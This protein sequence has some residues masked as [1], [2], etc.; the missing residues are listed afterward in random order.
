MTYERECPKCGDD[1]DQSTT[2]HLKGVLPGMAEC[3]VCY[4]VRYDKCAGCQGD[5]YVS[6]RDYHLIRK[7]L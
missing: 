5:G 1:L 2:C 4:P 6:R 3:P 7:T